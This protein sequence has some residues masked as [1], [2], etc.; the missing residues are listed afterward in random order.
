MMN[1][2]SLLHNH[3]VVST[4]PSCIDITV[5]YLYTN[6]I[7]NKVFKVISEIDFDIGSGDMVCNCTSS[8]FMYGPAGH[9]VTGNLR[10]VEDKHNI[11]ELLIKGL[12]FRQQ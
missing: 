4:I 6:T 2:L 7:V 9:V 12:S 1:L 11:R 10:I 3:K 8:P 5:S